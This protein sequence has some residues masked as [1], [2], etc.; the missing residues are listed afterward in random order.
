MLLMLQL[1]LTF[2]ILLYSGNSV[3]SGKENLETAKFEVQAAYFLVNVVI[4]QMCMD[5]V[6]NG[7]YMMRQVAFNPAAFSHPVTAYLMGVMNSWLYITIQALNI[8]SALSRTDFETILTRFVSYGALITIPQIY[9]RQKKMFN[10]KF[11]VDDFFLTINAESQEV[12]RSSS[13]M[14]DGSK[15]RRRII[16]EG[17]QQAKNSFSC[18]YRVLYHFTVG[19]YSMA[20]Y[21][22]GQMMIFLVPIYRIILPI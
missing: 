15:E 2:L 10:I 4:H 8:I 3:E 5:N 17:K 19:F 6:R 18:L 20:Y 21:Y 13:T 12:D 11:D 14:S 16:K 7:I 9:M 22:T 1:L